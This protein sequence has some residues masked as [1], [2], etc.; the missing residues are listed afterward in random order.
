MM[1]VALCGFA[2][3]EAQSDIFIYTYISNCIYDYALCMY[4]VYSMYVNVCTILCVCTIYMYIC[5]YIHI[6]VNIII[7]I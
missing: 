5:I 2:A 7:Y 1:Q 4:C 6:N 3:V